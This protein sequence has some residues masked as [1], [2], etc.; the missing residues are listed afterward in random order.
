MSWPARAVAAAVLLLFSIRAVADTATGCPPG[1]S[2]A[3]PP[4]SEL[5]MCWRIDDEVLRVE[6]SHPG[7]VWLALGFGE[8]MTGADAIVGRPDTGEVLDVF[9]A[10]LTADSITA[11]S[12]QDVTEAA[13]DFDRARTA[14]RFTRAL[15]TGDAEDFVI[16]SAAGDVSP[17]IWAV[18]DAPGF[19]GHF[20]RG[21]LRV[22]WHGGA[23][24]VWRTEVVFHAAL[25][26]L[27]WGALLPLGIV[28]AR[29]FKVLRSQDFP[30]EL[31]NRFWWN[32]H[33]ILQYGGVLVATVALLPVLRAHRD[34]ITHWHAAAGFV[35]LALG[36]LQVLGGVLRGSTGG[37]VDADGRPNPPAKIRGDHYDMTRRRRLF[38]F[39]HKKGGYLAALAGGIA[40]ALGMNTVGAPPLVW[41]AF[42]AW[43]CAL[44]VWFAW[45]QKSGRWVD[46]YIAIWG[47][48]ERHPGNRA[49]QQTA[50]GDP[51]HENRMRC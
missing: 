17:V 41:L 42:A 49:R 21:V 28:I 8:G 13:V 34:G 44:A 45:L 40:I 39:A 16:A 51:S 4:A 32:W 15:D 11:D 24:F 47:P 12:Q 6:M 19:D 50:T 27:A 26:L 38:E 37:P 43:L 22:D 1:W 36:Y 23:R 25:M 31:D 33:R 5:L 3:R 35:A 30:R 29:Y 18:G 7:R 2:K 48:D 46:T 9:I 10:G 14:L 20:A